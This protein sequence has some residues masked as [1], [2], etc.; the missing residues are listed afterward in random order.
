MVA[1]KL[2]LVITAALLAW[3]FLGC[4]HGPGPG[5]K[6]PYDH[7]AEPLDGL[8]TSALKGRKI[9]IDPGHGGIFRGARGVAGLDEADANL[10]VALHLARLLR[11]AGASVTLTRQTDCDLVEGDSLRLRDDLKARVAVSNGIDPDLFISLH[12]NA[13]LKFDPSF[14]EIQVYHRLDDD[15]PSL[16]AARAIAGRLLRNL[17]EDKCRVIGGNYHVLRN[18]IAPAVLCEPSFITNPS[19]E[20]MLKSDDKQLLEARAYFLGLVDYFSSGVP[21]VAQLGPSGQILEGRPTAWLTFNGGSV[22]DAASVEVTIDGVR[23]DA[24]RIGSDF[25][26]GSLP[27]PLASGRHTLTARARGVGGNASRKASVEFEVRLQPEAITL[28][29]SPPPGQQGDP[30]KI[31]ALVLDANGNPAAD[32]TRVVFTWDGGSTER[33]TVSGAAAVFTGRDVPA[34]EAGDTRKVT[35]ECGGLRTTLD[36]GRGPA[37]GPGRYFWTTGFITDVKGHP[38]AGAIIRRMPDLVTPDSLAVSG[39]P[40]VP[41]SAVASEPAA[42]LTSATSD[43]DGFFA[44]RGGG[45]PA[46][47]AAS[48]PGYRSATLDLSGKA[49]RGVRAGASSD[50]GAGATP[51][52]SGGT[53]VTI[54]L[55]RFYSDLDPTAVVMIDAAGG[56]AANERTG[57]GGFEASSINLAVADRLK[58]LLESVG[59]RALLTRETEEN[60]TGE[61]RVRRAEAARPTLLVSISHANGASAGGGL[62]RIGAGAVVSHYP[63][64]SGGARSARLIAEELHTCLGLEPQVAETA[65]YLVQQP[66]CTAVKVEFSGGIASD[67]AGVWMRAYSLMCGVLRFLGLDESKMFSIAGRV[68]AGGKACPGALLAI[69]GTMEIMADAKGEFTLRLLEPRSHTAEVVGE[70]GRGRAVTF[71]EATAGSGLEAGE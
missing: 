20:S 12:H 63:G 13:D 23:L 50:P 33:A 57:A 16:D 11:D 2:Q 28:T 22:I 62:G 32:S 49:G 7:P 17:G 14:N 19:V 27:A 43:A 38:L 25:F 6:R 30:R 3:C 26:L 51:E 18:S 9:V 52:V 21:H 60:T 42:V 53:P 34:G 15:G 1:V 45:P 56:A 70:S 58:S 54:S 8:D 24:R 36:L 69:D 4:A 31:T 61:E 55:E 37:T 35:A 44:L 41:N 64:S 40:V 48:K 46:A 65:D 29:A 5:T 68:A 59:V 39:Q 71:D 47:L 10:G 66:S 67:P